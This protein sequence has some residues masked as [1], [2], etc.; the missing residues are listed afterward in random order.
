LF[1][2]Q[3]QRPDRRGRRRHE[4]RDG[5]MIRKIGATTA[6]LPPARTISSRRLSASASERFA[7]MATA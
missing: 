7:W 4:V 3:R 6:A 2:Q 1:D 5:R